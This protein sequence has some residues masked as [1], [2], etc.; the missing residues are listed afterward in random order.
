MQETCSPAA[1]GLHLAI[2]AGPAEGRSKAN[3]ARSLLL[4]QLLVLRVRLL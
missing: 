3:A 1:L 4:R 2:A